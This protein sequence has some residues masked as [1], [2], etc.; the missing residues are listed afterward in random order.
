MAETR[1]CDWHD[2]QGLVL[3]GYNQLP[4]GECL[5][6]TF[7]DHQ[8]ISSWLKQALRYVSRGDDP[9][10][11][12]ACAIALSHGGTAQGVGLGRRICLGQ[13]LAR[14]HGGHVRR[15]APQPHSGR[16]R[17]SDPSTWEWGGGHGKVDALVFACAESQERLRELRGQ[18]APAAGEASAKT[19]SLTDL[20]G[21]EHFGFRDGVSQPILETTRLA[22]HHPDSHHIVKLGEMLLGYPDNGGFVAPVPAVLD[23]EAFGRNGSYLVCRQLEQDVAK[24][25]AFVA[26]AAEGTGLDAA[27]GGGDRQGEDAGSPERRLAS[28]A[29]VGEWLD[30]RGQR[31]RVLRARS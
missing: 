18:L 25:D 1:H 28:A 10:S 16:Q 12:I 11:S 27:A 9:P 17:P 8:S 29:H 13:L 24:F 2:V 15:P 22:R 14:V 21:A 20:Y 30:G 19:I 31:V 26:R 4:V 7:R 3:R 5:I 23:N 6:L